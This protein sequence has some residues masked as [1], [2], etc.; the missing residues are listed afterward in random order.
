MTGIRV[1]LVGC[2]FVSELHMYAFRRVYGVDVEVA[3][4][5]ARGDKVVAFARHHNIPRVY[6]SFDELIADG[7]LDVID[8]CTPPS[9]HAEMIVASM[10]A[11]KH[12]ICEKPFAGYFG[13]EGDTQ[14]IGKHV[15]KAL[16]YERVIEEM[17][18]TRAAIERTGKL[19]MY[20]EDWIYAPAVTKTAEIIKAT[21][22]KILFMKGEESHSG[23][24]AAHAAQWAMTGGGSLI[25]MGCHP[26]SA[27]L[28]LKQVEARARGE[29]IHVASVTGDVGNVTAALKPEERS[30]IKA[31]PVDVE[32][33]GTLTATF[34]DGTKATIFSGDMIM[35]GV[36]NLIETYTSGGSLFANITPNNHL[37]SY[38][39]SEEKLASVYITEKVDR[40]TGW[41]YVCLEEEWT[42]GFLQ[43]IQ[44]FMECAATGRQPLSDLALAYETIKVNYAGYWAAEEGR[45]VVL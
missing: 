18:R 11:G 3:A 28:Y 14:P 35:G 33:W 9:L 6:R 32:D 7:E 45:R 42:R 27:V 40:K 16:M 17:D 38:Q 31:N 2:G 10:E 29:S 12:V 13:R 21:K 36:R 20:A 26:L 15:P 5:A 19:F 25:R 41:Q 23:S 8:I 43:E 34:S 1:G 24:H 44:D 4:V 30:Y 37:M 39:T 22:D